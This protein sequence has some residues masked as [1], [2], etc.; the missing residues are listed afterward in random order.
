[1][2]S[3]HILQ[4]RTNPLSW[5]ELP[6]GECYRETL[7]QELQPWWPKLFGFH[8]LKLGDLSVPLVTDKCG[9]L[10]QVNVGLA[11]SGLQVIAKSYPLPFIT[12]SVDAC[13]LA[14]TLCYAEDPCRLLREVDRVLIDNGWLLI[15]GFNP[16]S[17]L[18]LYTLLLWLRKHGLRKHEPYISYTFSQIRILNWL[19]LLNYEVLHQARFHVIPWEHKSDKF[20][21][22]HLLALGCMSVIVAR[23][24]TSPL[25]PTRLK[26][27][28]RRSSLDHA[29]GVIKSYRNFS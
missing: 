8:L 5:S 3:V 20:L 2:K 11:G 6:W 15:S 26:R 1:M 4:N 12:K 9:I 22:A 14:H 23:K 24:R 19:S 16:F 21:C 18:G 29:I 17:L 28:T 27:C 10:H 25:T 7:E 13:L